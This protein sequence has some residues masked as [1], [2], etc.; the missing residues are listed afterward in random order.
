MP[1]YSR[2]EL[3][4]MTENFTQAIELAEETGDWK[5]LAIMYTEDAQYRWNVGPNEEFY[6]NGRKEI[7]AYAMGAQMQGLEEWRYPYYDFLI[8]EE[9]GEV[10]GFFRQIS[11]FKREDG[12]HYEIEGISGSRFYYGGNY[13][14]KEQRD[15]FD[16]GNLK[17][18]LIELAAIDALEPAFK[19]NIQKLA[20]GQ[21]LPGNRKIRPEASLLTKAKGIAAM[22]KIA[23]TGR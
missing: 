12:S 23:L 17:A 7:E 20:K 14:W 19:K 11:P 6:A 15:F 16:V 18:L 5:P 10:V 2:E 8:D 13:Q 1:K 9:R 3:K 22:L 4:E 21:L